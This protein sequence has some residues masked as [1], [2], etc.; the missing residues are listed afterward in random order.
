MGTKNGYEYCDHCN[1]LAYVK[2]V[3]CALEGTH[4]QVPCIPC[5]GQGFWE[6]VTTAP[7]SDTTQQARIINPQVAPL[8]QRPEDKH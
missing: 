4:V 2:Q 8:P 1:G 3:I 7:T 5:E 6:A